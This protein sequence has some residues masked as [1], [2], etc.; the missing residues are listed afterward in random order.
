MLTAS[1]PT[2]AQTT[3]HASTKSP[4]DRT[5]L[6]PDN[7]LPENPE[8]GANEPPTDGTA[9]QGEEELNNLL[10]AVDLRAA[11]TKKGLDVTIVRPVN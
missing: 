4:I 7:E 10:E 8:H 5:T 2:E 6:A 3:H 9:K 1:P 11:S